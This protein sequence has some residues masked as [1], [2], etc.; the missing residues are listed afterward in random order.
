[1]N[2][3]HIDPPYVP[4]GEQIQRL[5][6]KIQRSWSERQRREREV[7]GDRKVQVPCYSVSHL[8][9]DVFAL[10]DERETVLF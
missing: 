4:T 10:E 3:H 6:E 5:C 1:M 7:P 2:K 8:A 9:V